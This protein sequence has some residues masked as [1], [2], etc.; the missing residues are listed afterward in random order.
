MT[1]PISRPLPPV[2]VDRA[3]IVDDRIAASGFG[4]QRIRPETGYRRRSRIEGILS[5]AGSGSYLRAGSAM[6]FSIAGKDLLCS[7]VERARHRSV[8]SAHGKAPGIC[9]RFS[10]R[11]AVA[12]RRR[13]SDCPV[14]TAPVVV[15]SAVATVAGVDIGSTTDCCVDALSSRR[16]A[17]RLDRVRLAALFMKSQACAPETARPSEAARNSSLVILVFLRFMRRRAR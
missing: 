12:G 14:M 10:Q 5:D 7:E 15:D 11:F 1:A 16:N 17:G 6:S 2:R 9:G 8:S 3:T 13:Y 4:H